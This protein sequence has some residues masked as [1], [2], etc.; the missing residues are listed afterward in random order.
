MR[1]WGARR[2]G[3]AALP[4]LLASACSNAIV[5]AGIDRGA[6]PPPAA[7]AAPA[8]PATQASTRYTPGVKLGTPATPMPAIPAAAAP[9]D[10]T[11]AVTAGWVAGPAI[12]SLPIDAGAAQRA[13]AAFR[14]S[15][16]S[17]QKRTDAT[18]F[19]LSA[20]LAEVV[21]LAVVHNHHP[22]VSGVHGPVAGR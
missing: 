11:S 2:V 21:D 22:A 12:A 6:P 13:L 8:I 20:Q 18:A 4:L 3:V 9:A 7:P 14:L 19:T 5:P 1:A 10:A 16:A 15:C 17:L